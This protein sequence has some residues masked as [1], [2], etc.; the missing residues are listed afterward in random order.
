VT[1]ISGST[2]EPVI[3]DTEAWKM[4]PEDRVIW[5]IGWLAFFVR[6]AEHYHLGT[7]DAVIDMTLQKAYD[8]KMD[9]ERREIEHVMRRAMQK[10]E[11][12]L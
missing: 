11:G 4:T 3:E 9:M 1:W 5:I 12:K 2:I 7:I 6:N 8:H 10:A